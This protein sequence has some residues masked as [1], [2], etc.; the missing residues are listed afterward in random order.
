MTLGQN[1]KMLR[2]SRY[3]SMLDLEE[4]TGLSKSTIHQI[5]RDTLNPTFDTIGTLD[6]IAH[7]LHTTTDE[8]LL[9]KPINSIIKSEGI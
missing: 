2:E 9:T 8:L 6:K 4:I 5:E 7:A 1:I 3:M